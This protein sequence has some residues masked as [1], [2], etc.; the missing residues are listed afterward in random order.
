M[1][2]FPCLALPVVA[3]PCGGHLRQPSAGY[4]EDP[5]TG[6]TIFQSAICSLRTV[7]H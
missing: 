5:L 4:F 7:S 6:K 3:C 2:M 1:K